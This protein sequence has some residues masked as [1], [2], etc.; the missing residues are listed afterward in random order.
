MSTATVQDAGP[1]ANA[2]DNG[3]APAPTSR[4]AA[5]PNTIRT[6]IF[7]KMRR[8]YPWMKLDAIRDAADRAAKIIPDTVTEQ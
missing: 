3:Q 2:G 4:E 5:M 8:T 6:T 1:R 7:R